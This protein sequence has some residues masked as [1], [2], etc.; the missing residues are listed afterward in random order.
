M[1]EIYF[2]FCVT[3]NSEL[4]LTAIDCLS[5]YI[6][7]KNK[8]YEVTLTVKRNDWEIIMCNESITMYPDVDMKFELREKYF[9]MVEM[10]LPNVFILQISIN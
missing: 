6:V 2:P 7:D 1:L 9:K 4:F 8:S 10:C 5:H 3:Q